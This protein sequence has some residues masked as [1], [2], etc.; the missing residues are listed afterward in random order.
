VKELIKVTPDK[1]KV[2]NILKMASLIEERI[3]IQ[4]KKKMTALIIAD[5]Y[6]IVKELITAKLL[7]DGYKTLGHKE[8]INYISKSPK[9]SSHEIS[10]LDDLRVLRNRVAYNGFFIEPSYLLRNENLFKELIQKLKDSVK[11]KL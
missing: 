7:L 1:E 2:K 11:D 9:L 5:Y 3:T 10:V 6:E 4:D 8:L